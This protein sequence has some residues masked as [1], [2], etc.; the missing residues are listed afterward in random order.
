MEQVTDKAHPNTGL[1]VKVALWLGLITGVE[2][3][4]SYVKLASWITITAMIALAMIKFVVVVGYFMHLKFDHPTL[5]KPFI[6]GF[7]LAVLIYGVV[8]L[9]MQLHSNG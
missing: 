1:Y 9:N 8:L 3:V 2:I 5:R 4:L 6:T 7:V